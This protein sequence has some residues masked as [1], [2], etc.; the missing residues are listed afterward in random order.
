[1]ISEP[2]WKKSDHLR[3]AGWRPGAGALGAALPRPE[4]SH[5]GLPPAQTPL[6][7]IMHPWWKPRGAEESYKKDLGF[8]EVFLV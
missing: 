3:P 7:T 8:L 2:P 1:M 6:K 4:C 5:P